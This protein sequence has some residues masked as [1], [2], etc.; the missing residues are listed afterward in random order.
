MYGGSAVRSATFVGQLVVCGFV[1]IWYFYRQFI[2]ILTI[3]TR[4][5][6][7]LPWK[8]STLREEEKL[9]PFNTMLITTIGPGH[10]PSL[11]NT[12]MSQTSIIR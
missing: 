6:P 12:E 8:R 4:L 11:I 5:P 1:S 7:H 2:M 3:C 10:Q 9:Y